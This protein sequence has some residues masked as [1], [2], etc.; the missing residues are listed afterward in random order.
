VG[1]ESGMSVRKEGYRRRRFDIVTSCNTHVPFADNIRLLPGRKQPSPVNIMPFRDSWELRFRTQTRKTS[2]SDP[3]STFS[4]SLVS[5]TSPTLLPVLPFHV[6]IALLCFHSH[7]RY[8]RPR[9]FS[10]SEILINAMI[11]ESIYQTRFHVIIR[12]VQISTWTL[13][14]LI[15]C[16]TSLITSAF[17]FLESFQK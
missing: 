7:F 8:S 10:P 3:D 12:H 13:I 15:V 6:Y 14:P 16:L 2:T 9:F 1:R 17:R 4:L 5:C 11:P